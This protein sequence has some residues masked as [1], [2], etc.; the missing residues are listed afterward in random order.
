MNIL[1]TGITGFI[2]KNFYRLNGNS[3][4]KIKAFAKKESVN[5]KLFSGLNYLNCNFD[6]FEKFSK[7]IIEFKPDIVLNMAWKG[8]PDYSKENSIY[9]L[10]KTLSFF[11]FLTEETDLKK[12][13]NTGTC[14]EYFYPKGKISEDYE[15]KHQ[16]NFSKAKINLNEKLQ[17]E[18]QKKGINYINLRLFYV[19]GLHQREQSIIPYLINCYK[20]GKNPLVTTPYNKLDYVYV[21]DVVSA[22]NHCIFENIPNGSYNVGSGVATF[23]Y[24]VQEIISKMMKFKFDYK[25]SYPLENKESINFFADIDKLK[26]YSEW[27]PRYDLSRGIKNILG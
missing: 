21:D 13:I 5:N 18:S 9:S 7:E 24:Q 8:I 11:E 20:N 2:G 16:D 15:I 27:R 3:G 6:N 19:Y 25:H 4:L 1:V 10:D 26:N 14:A 23:N 22:I 12:F 17:S